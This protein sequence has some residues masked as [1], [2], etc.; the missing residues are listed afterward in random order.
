MEEI[1]VVKHDPVERTDT[2]ATLCDDIKIQKNARR[3]TIL[4]FCKRYSALIIASVS[5]VLFIITFVAI[6]LSSG[7]ATITKNKAILVEAFKN[8]PFVNHVTIE[9]CEEEDYP[10]LIAEVMHYTAIQ[11]DADEE[12][13]TYVEFNSFNEKYNKKHT[14]WKHKKQC[15]INFRGNVSSIN[16]HNAREDKTF[17]KEM[18]H[19]G[20]LSAK[21]F[22]DRY[23]KKVEI[24]FPEVPANHAWNNV[25]P[26]ALDLRKRDFMT[27]VK[28][29]G[30]F[31][32]SWAYSATAIA[33]SYHKY[34]RN[35]DIS[36]SE[37][38]LIDGVK[39]SGSTP[40]NNPF[41]G[42]K[43]IKDLGLVESST[44]ETD[45]EITDAPRYT[46][47]SYSYTFNPDLVSLLFNSGPLTIAVSV[48]ED[49]QFYKSG[50]INKCGAELNHFVTLVGVG[51]DRESNYWII[52]NSFGAE[53]GDDG[54]IKLLRGNPEEADDCGVAS[55]AMYSV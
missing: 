24:Q 35:I 34:N 18:N 52:K 15:F 40:V 25:R 39:E 11:F 7:S 38:Q 17:T 29:Q 44:Y 32:C 14:S 30:E 8:I 51:F 42:Y 47:G 9:G 22:L 54:Y 5:S 33:E 19:M 13:A 46:I 31:G 55:F 49:W 6:A 36:L 50:T 41:L 20:D 16:E 48:S 53:W 45:V 43:Y 37:K 26:M 21:E 12:A 3:A 2:E 27:P 10:L 28:D 1:E 4:A 23:T